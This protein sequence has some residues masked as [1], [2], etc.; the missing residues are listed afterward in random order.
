MQEEIVI[1]GFG[2]QG[3]LFAGQLLAYAA[4]DQGRY[5]TWWPSYGP[6]MRGGTAH[7]IVIISDAPIGA[8]LV[9]HPSMAIVLNQPSF[10]KYEPL[11]KAGG[12]LVVNSS[13]V[14]GCSQRNDITCLLVP[15]ND[16]ANG[17]GDVRMAN[18]V[19]LGALL[20]V[21]PVVSLEA[22]KQ[23]LDE[24]IPARRQKI[25]EPNKKALMAGA[26]Y[27]IT[28]KGVQHG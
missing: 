17:L 25:I 21:R 27:V 8:P 24:H 19:L 16:I 4:M 23:T 13:L 12:V 1:S 18:V 7:C 10:D 6:E 9:H 28:E 3:T 22:V 11:V 26:E 5:V 20:A 14:Q 2:G 15:G